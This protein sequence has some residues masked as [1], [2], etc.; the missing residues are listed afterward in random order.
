[1]ICARC[2]KPI[3]ANEASEVIVMES[4]SGVHP[5]T[6]LHRRLCARVPSQVTPASTAARYLPATRTTR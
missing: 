4:A 3:R 6:H 1:M 2:Q 5:D